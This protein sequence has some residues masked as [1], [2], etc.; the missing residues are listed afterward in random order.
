MK[1]STWNLDCGISIMSKI[2]AY[3]LTLRQE[4]KFK[5][6]IITLFS[7]VFI[8]VENFRKVKTKIDKIF[9]V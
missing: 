9:L 5:E 3:L 2:S 1:N 4:K 8:K 7:E 6:N